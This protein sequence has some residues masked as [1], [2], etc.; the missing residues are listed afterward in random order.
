VAREYRVSR[1]W[2]HELIK[3]SAPRV[4]P[5]WSRAPADPTE[6]PPRRRRGLEEE[7]V[8]LRKALSDQ[9][10]DSGAPT[11]TGESGSDLWVDTRSWSRVA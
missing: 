1:R 9:G 10:L 4:R 3:Y 5:A 11:N 7:I 2:V 8:E 6:A